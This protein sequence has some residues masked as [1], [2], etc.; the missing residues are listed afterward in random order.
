MGGRRR[1][2]VK[3]WGEGRKKGWKRREGMCM[4]KEDEEGRDGDEEGRDGDEEGR[5]KDEGGEEARRVG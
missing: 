5:D 4:K 3:Q 2:I 1:K